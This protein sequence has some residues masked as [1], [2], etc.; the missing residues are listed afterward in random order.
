[1]KER[2]MLTIDTTRVTRE[3]TGLAARIQTALEERNQ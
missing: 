2:E 1:M 3:A